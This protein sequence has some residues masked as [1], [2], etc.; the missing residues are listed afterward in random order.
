MNRKTIAQ[1]QKLYPALNVGKAARPA[2]FWV[3]FF[4][5]FV[6]LSALVSPI[7][8]QQIFDRV[9][10]SRH[11]ETLF[12]LTMVVIG[13][14]AMF[15]MLDAVRGGI[16]AKIATWWD[17]AVQPD[18]LR[19]TVQ[20]A[21]A[22]GGRELGAMSD[23]AQVRQFVGSSAILPIFDAP[24]MPLFLCA[25]ALIHPVL[26]MVALATAICLFALAAINDF[27]VRRRLEGVGGFQRRA[28]QT[29]DLAVQNAE[30][31]HALDMLPG[32]LAKFRADSGLAGTAQHRVATYTARMA[33]F[34]K[35]M[36]ITAQI[37]VLGLG[38]YFAMLGEMTSGGMIAASIILGR[39]LAPA[40]QALG[41]WRSF[42]AARQAHARI[43]QILVGA[44]A[45]EERMQ[46]PPLR[47]RVEFSEIGLRLPGALRPVL[48]GVTL[49]IPEATIVAIVGPS[50]S[51]KSTLCKMLIGAIEP[52]AGSIRI[53]G[54][55]VSNWNRPELARQMGYLG[56]KVELFDGTVAE[57]IARFQEPDPAKVMKA[58]SLA[59]CHDLVNGLPDGYETQVGPGG[60]NLSGG[61]AQ[62][63]GLA[64][65]IYGDPK[66]L[67]L[68]E[69]NANLDASGDES[70]QQAIRTLR[71][72]GAT[73]VIV[74][75][76]TTALTDVDLVVSMNAGTIAKTRTRDEFLREIFTPVSESIRKA[77]GVAEAPQPEAEAQPD[78]TVPSPTQEDGANAEI[79][80]TT[81][82]A[83]ATQGVEESSAR[84]AKAPT[85]TVKRDLRAELKRAMREAAEKKNK[86]TVPPVPAS[87]G[88]TQA[89]ADNGPLRL[90][91]RVDTGAGEE[92]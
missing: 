6:N 57:N 79:P 34:S 58:A 10:Q 2:F 88:R 91:N 70:L 25:I 63:I 12:F 77:A 32:V 9:M 53:D 33:A 28:S 52:S 16:L 46:Q 1:Q 65:A 76:K 45:D 71:K 61:Q 80:S 41:A 8:M 30:T 20:T 38:A 37:A 11:L 64:R 86:R 67:V 31:I 3:G 59:G 69:P 78:T 62:R 72:E 26:G 29:A 74:S 68:D 51:G 81:K 56:Q 60:L 42:V 92:G 13:A 40:E 27:V 18:L 49:T 85:M 89:G 48:R 14:L 55:E 36:R 5:F 7:Y 84:A 19:A 15:A 23:L 66:L 39:A 75:H 47:G 54:A 24:W 90:T 82:A 4:S 83:A 50:G 17:E 35:F 21:R 87:P 43:H 44:P 22:R 73:I